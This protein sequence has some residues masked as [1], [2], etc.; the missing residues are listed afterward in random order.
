[1]DGFSIPSLLLFPFDGANIS[2]FTIAF[3][4]H[5]KRAKRFSDPVEEKGSKTPIYPC[6][7]FHVTISRC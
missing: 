7:P 2:V 3:L 6:E 4:G 1:M 5:Q